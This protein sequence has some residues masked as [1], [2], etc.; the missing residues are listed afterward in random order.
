ML[1]ELMAWQSRQMVA[2][3]RRL[4]ALEQAQ[5]DVAGKLQVLVAAGA[6]QRGAAVAGTGARSQRVGSVRVLGAGRASR[7]RPPS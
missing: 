6:A 7:R 2:L 4:T 1:E 5:D 3:H